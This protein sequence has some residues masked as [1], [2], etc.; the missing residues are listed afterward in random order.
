MIEAHYPSVHG[1][2]LLV[3]L[4]TDSRTCW[5]GKGVYGLYRHGLL[6]L[7][8]DLGTVAAIHLYASGLS[9]H[10]KDIWFAMRH[11][12]YRSTAESVYY[13]LRRVEG[14][15]LVERT[16]WGDWRSPRR[17]LRR[18][19][20]ERLLGANRRDT[21]EILRRTDELMDAGLVELERRLAGRP[22]KAVRS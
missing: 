21:R 6:P 14:E 9:L 5:G 1:A 2:S 13:G 7:T 16:A 17:G 4:S 22:S 18:D 8:S 12:G 19:R 10:Y 20:I 11:T 3:A 15:G